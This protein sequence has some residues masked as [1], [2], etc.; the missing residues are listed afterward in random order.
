MA[1][2]TGNPVVEVVTAGRQDRAMG[3][4]SGVPHFH[5]HITQE[6]LLPL[7]IQTL[8]KVDAVSRRLKGEHLRARDTEHKPSNSQHC[9]EPV[10]KTRLNT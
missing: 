10:A 5:G 6:V 2:D 4:E 8:E 9:A 7:V 3:S 1:G